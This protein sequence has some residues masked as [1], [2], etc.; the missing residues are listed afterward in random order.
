MT[1]IELRSARL[2][3]G[4]SLAEFARLLGYDGNQIKSTAHRLEIG[5]RTIR[6]PQRRLVEAYLAG[7]RPDDWP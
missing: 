7:Y 5:Q 2:R 6:E 4:L 1:H 3:L